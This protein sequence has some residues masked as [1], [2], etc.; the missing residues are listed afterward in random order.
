[1]KNTTLF[2][3]AEFPMMASV[4]S[5]IQPPKTV[6]DI[7]TV[8]DVG[9]RGGCDAPNIPNELRLVTIIKKER[10]G[11][12][13]VV[14]QEE[15]TSNCVIKNSGNGFGSDAN[16]YYCFLCRD[17]FDT[18][19]ELIN[20]IEIHF[21]VSSVE[22]DAESSMGRDESVE[23]PVSSGECTEHIEIYFGV[24]DLEIK[25]ESSVAQ[26]ASFKTPLSGGYSNSS[27][28]VSGVEIDA[29]SS[30]GRDESVETPVSSCECTEHIENH[31]GF[32]DFEIKPESSVAQDASFKTPLSSGYSN[33]SCGVSGVEI[34]AESSMGRDESVETPVSSGECTEHKEINFGVSDLEIKRKSSVAQDEYFKTPIYSG[35][36]DNSCGVSGVEIDAESSMGRDE[37]V[38]TPVSSGEC[39][40]HIENHF[41][42]SDLEIKPESSVAQDESFKTPISSG[43]SDNS[44]DVS[45]VEIDAESSIGRDESVETPVSSGECTEHIENHFGF[46]DLEIK[47][48]SSVAQDESF[49][50]PL[51]SGCSNSSCE[52][53]SSKALREQRLTADKI[54]SFSIPD[55]GQCDG[56]HI[57]EFKSEIDEAKE[58]G[59]GGTSG[60]DAPY[61]P[62]TL[63]CVR[64]INK[65]MIGTE[66]V[67]GDKEEPSNCLNKNVG[68]SFGS[69]ENSYNCFHC[70]DGFDTKNELVDHIKIHSSVS[71][72]EID[73][74][75]SMERDE[76]LETP[77]SSGE[78][79]GSNEPSTT[80]SLKQLKSG[81]QVL[82]QKGNGDLN[83]ISGRISEKDNVRSSLVVDGK[84]RSESVSSTSS[85]DN[86]NI[87]HD[88]SARTNDESYACGLCF[89][90]FTE[91]TFLKRHMNTHAQEKLYPCK[92]CNKS[93]SY[94]SSLKIHMR[95]HTGVKSFSCNECLR[96][97]SVKSVL[98]IHMRTHSGERPYACSVC[99]K[100]FATASNLTKH[101]RTH[102][103]ETL[104]MRNMPQV[105]P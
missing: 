55:D 56:K 72:L 43:D 25:P 29:E 28:G 3:L 20:H 35:D 39:T 26:D 73:S 66:A 52:L 79:N 95:S 89:K 101:K 31:F 2:H 105:F 21:G 71:S 68:N 50:T 104:S 83:K 14:G 5:N 75:S 87:L 44:C 24:S 11:S 32:S 48:E 60:C 16:S 62:N 4:V 18:K 64:V 13:T 58:T 12:E 7:T 80:F 86:E 41:G 51:P 74:E 102:I 30:M 94:S 38:E 99:G 40:E 81:R 54:K 42:F 70:R 10:S 1:M 47:P 67:M 23:T 8:S 90:F 27:C 82:G 49:K 78:C 84:S 96:S 98:D 97:F 91:I 15:E 34:A 61:L 33:S 63:R 37:S 100:Y 59:D 76:S 65:R 77:V 17:G 57:T 36:S 69:N 103:G 45:G 9:S 6:G 22:I 93:F 19:N 53:I 85:S 88:V 46:S 92:A